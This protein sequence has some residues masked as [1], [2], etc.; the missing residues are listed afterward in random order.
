MLLYGLESLETLGLGKEILGT[1]KETFLHI[2]KFSSIFL[3]IGSPDSP[4]QQVKTHWLYQ[5]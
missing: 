4:L 3:W 5:E 2:T 1:R